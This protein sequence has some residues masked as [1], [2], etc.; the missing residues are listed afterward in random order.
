MKNSIIESGISFSSISYVLS[1]K[2]MLLLLCCLLGKVLFIFRQKVLWSFF[3][4]C[5][6]LSM[7]CDLAQV[8]TLLFYFQLVL[9]FS[10]LAC[11]SRTSFSIICIISS[12]IQGSFFW[13]I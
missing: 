4:S 11:N 8:M 10:I 13:F 7:Y 5:K 12:F 1:L 9:L 2:N 3:A 6:E